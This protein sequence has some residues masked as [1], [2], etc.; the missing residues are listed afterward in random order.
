MTGPDAVRSFCDRPK[1]A[2][3]EPAI[4]VRDGMANDLP[5]LVYAMPRELPA[6]LRLLRAAK[7]EMTEVHHFADYPPAV[8]DLVTQLGVPY[9]VHV[10][11]YAWFCPRVSLVGAHDRYCGE[12]DLARLRSLR[13]RQ[14]PF[15]EREYHGRRVARPIRG[16]VLGRAARRRALGR[17][18]HT[19][20]AAFRRTDDND[21]RA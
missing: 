1:R 12:P 2:G 18:R 14:R 15:S 5:N 20:A 8:Y 11:D 9:D 19:D 4:A 17:Y 21:R 16:I 10:H 13:R 6:L 7:P 3:G